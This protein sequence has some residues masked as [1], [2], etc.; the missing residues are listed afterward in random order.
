[1][2]GAIPRQYTQCK[3]PSGSLTASFKEFFVMSCKNVS[4]KLDEQK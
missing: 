3:S 2:L 4:E 1:M